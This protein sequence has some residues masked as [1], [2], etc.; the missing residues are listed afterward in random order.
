MELSA[1]Q[2]GQLTGEY[3]IVYNQNLASDEARALLETDVWQSVSAVA[4]GR[5]AVI[6][7]SETDFLLLPWGRY[8]TMHDLDVLEDLLTPLVQQ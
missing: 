4:A 8:G 7:T 6:D 3:L 1:E 5:Y 2:V